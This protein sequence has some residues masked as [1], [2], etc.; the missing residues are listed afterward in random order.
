MAAPA[1]I[2]ELAPV[3]R[4][5]L[6]DRDGPPL[7]ISGEERSF[8]VKICDLLERNI[9]L[10]PTKVGSGCIIV[11]TIQYKHKVILKE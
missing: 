10:M 4:I 1:P 2:P 8:K 7:D 11:K 9:F 6:P 5:T 3:S